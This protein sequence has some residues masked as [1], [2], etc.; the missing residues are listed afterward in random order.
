MSNVSGCGYAVA[1]TMGPENI[2][3]I[4]LRK[5]LTCSAHIHI[6]AVSCGPLKLAGG[7]PGK[8]SFRSS[9]RTECVGLSSPG[10]PSRRLIAIPEFD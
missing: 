2:L 4:L 7:R 1:C 5:I 9:L 10:D 3:L 8:G 6:Y